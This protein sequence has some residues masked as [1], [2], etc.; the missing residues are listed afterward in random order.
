MHYCLIFFCIY[1]VESFIIN[2]QFH[3]R[4]INRSVKSKV[5][6]EI[7]DRLKKITLLEASEL[8]KQIEETFGVS[9]AAAAAIAPAPQ[10]VVAEAEEEEVEEVVVVEQSDFKVSLESVP[11][12]KR[13][14]MIKV[15][16][17]LYPKKNLIEAKCMIDNLPK[18]L[19]D[20]LPKDEALEVKKKVEEAGGV[21]LL[22]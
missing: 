4:S 9:A 11:Q 2:T 19:F 22:E 8:V 14:A 1:N 5:T 21:C 12:A 6:D 3:I 15:M 18:I 17:G 16:K 10:A 7:V 20:Q 13:M